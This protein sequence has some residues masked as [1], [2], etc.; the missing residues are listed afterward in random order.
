[1]GITQTETRGGRPDTLMVVHGSAVAIGARGVLILGASGRGKSA[2]ALRL[3][4]LGAELVADDRTIVQAEAGRLIATCPEQLRG[5]IEARGV[6]LLKAVPATRAEVVLIVD[7]DTTET[8]RLPVPR[9][10]E[11]D[12]IALPCL[13]N[14]ER[15]YF[16]AAI[17]QYLKCG[18]VEVS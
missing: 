3:M 2:L 10:R 17:L 7:L 6:G 11:I 18:R 8:E 16:P 13:H 4:A 5:M 9:L 12:G 15:G 1:M 14:V